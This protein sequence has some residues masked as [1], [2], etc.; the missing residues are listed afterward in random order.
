[1]I[2]VMVR[3]I[4]SRD[5]FGVLYPMYMLRSVCFGPCAPLCTFIQIS[6]CIYNH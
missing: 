6:L 3:I 2:H 1:M 4:L 5:I